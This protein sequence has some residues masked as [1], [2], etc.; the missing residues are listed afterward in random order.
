M[1][2]VVQLFAWFIYASIVAVLTGLFNFYVLLHRGLGLSL[3]ELK[4]PIIV[5][6]IVFLS[7]APVVWWQHTHRNP[8]GSYPYAR[9]T[10]TIYAIIIIMIVMYYVGRFIGYWQIE[11]RM[12]IP[13]LVISAI[14]ILT[15][16][17]TAWLAFRLSSP[18]ALGDRGRQH[19][20][21]R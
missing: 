20:R 7:A 3:A 17:V 11:I 1:R 5:W 10:G 8:D 9:F 21:N 13:M 2:A 14:A 12:S 4:E 18:T 15:G 19:N 6:A 16:I